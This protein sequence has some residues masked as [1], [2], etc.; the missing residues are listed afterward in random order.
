M[1]RNAVSEMER[2]KRESVQDAFMEVC[3][4]NANNI[5]K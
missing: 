2:V 1:T 3:L 4:A 5:C